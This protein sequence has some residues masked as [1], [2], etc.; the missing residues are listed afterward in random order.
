MARNEDFSNSFWDHPDIEDLSADATLLYIWSWTNPR[1]GMAGIYEVG[2]RAMS[3]S[4]VVADRLDVTLVELVDAGK[5]RYE[6]GVLFVLK[7]VARL[8]TK[9]PQVAKSVAKDLSLMP[10]GHPLMDAWLE[11][12]GSDS[13]LKG[14]LSEARVRLTRG[15]S[16]PHQK[17]DPV[18]NSVSL[19]QTSLE[20]HQRLQVS[21]RDSGR[22]RG[23]GKESS[24]GKAAVDA[25]AAMGISQ[26]ELPDG[27]PPKLAAVADDVLG[28]L[29]RI[30]TKR[31]GVEPTRFG[32]GLAISEFEDR[33]HRLVVSALEH[34]ALAGTG[35]NGQVRDWARTYRTFLERSPSATPI[36]N[37]RKVAAKRAPV[38]P[39]T[40]DDI[41]QW[42]G[43]I[44]DLQSA[45]KD[46]MF[47]VWL[48]QLHPHGSPGAGLLLGSRA[49]L[50]AWIRD[51]YGAAIT[52][53]AGCEVEIVEC[54]CELSGEQSA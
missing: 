2:R 12:Y 25:D 36:A 22:G 33:D 5:V 7:R 8:R 44:P 6:A 9:S 40:A 54:G 10:D 38:Q 16:E 37:A 26:D 30:H 15:S 27:L 31:G 23:S 51:R 50:G 48:D 47:A 20:P 19:T 13:W 35:R 29:L 32:V 1:C 45:V 46:E 24:Q 43:V 39:A 49:G 18:S 17:P 41:A 21:G 52:S 11:R 28:V 42:E 4:K 53:I 34:W 3:E 14:A